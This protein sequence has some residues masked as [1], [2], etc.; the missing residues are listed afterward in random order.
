MTKS[1]IFLFIVHFQNKSDKPE[2]LGFRATSIQ[3]A[4]HQLLKE[5]KRLKKVVSKVIPI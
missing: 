3:K 5:I 1:R 4:E 2:T